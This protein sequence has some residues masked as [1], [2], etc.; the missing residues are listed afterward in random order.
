[1]IRNPVYEADLK[2]TTQNFALPLFKFPFFEDI[3]NLGNNIRV[4]RTSEVTNILASGG[5]VTTTVEQSSLN[6]SQSETT[7]GTSSY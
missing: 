6:T 5:G 3:D 4:A 7:T 2:Q 1:M